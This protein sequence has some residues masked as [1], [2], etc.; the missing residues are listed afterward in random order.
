MPEHSLRMGPCGAMAS[1]G[2]ARR[3]SRSGRSFAETEEGAD[4]LFRSLVAEAGSEPV[5]LDLPGAESGSQA[6]AA[7]YGFSP[8]FGTARM[9]RGPDPRLPLSRI[10]GITTFELEDDRATGFTASRGYAASCAKTR[11]TW[12][13]V[14]PRA[15]AFEF[16]RTGRGGV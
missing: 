3:G 16:C 12:T 13:G 2:A 6:L 9:Y 14:P 11:K 4:A 5:F 1:S 7:R 8:V 15:I 10:F